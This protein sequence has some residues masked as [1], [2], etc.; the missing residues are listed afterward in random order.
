MIQGSHTLDHDQAPGDFGPSPSRAVTT[1][2]FTLRSRRLLLLSF[3]Q[4]RKKIPNLRSYFKQASQ[5]RSRSQFSAAG[6]LS[7]ARRDLFGLK[8][9]KL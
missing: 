9:E 1:N 6:N 5:A 2:I 3:V 8:G 4:P 7:S